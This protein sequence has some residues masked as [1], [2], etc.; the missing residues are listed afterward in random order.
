M[1]LKSES[2]R[3]KADNDGLARAN[4]ELVVSCGFRAGMV[5]IH[6]FR[7]AMHDVVVDAVF[8]VRSAVLDTKQP[9]RIGLVLGEKQ[10]WRAFTM[11]PAVA[12]PVDDSVRSPGSEQDVP[13]AAPADDLSFPTTMCCGTT[14]SAA[15]EDS[16]LPAHGSRP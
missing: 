16:P 8:D 3:R 7:C 9:L 14:P 15:G 11:Q 10:F 4:R 1:P 13:D 12:R 2:A 6:R 5:G